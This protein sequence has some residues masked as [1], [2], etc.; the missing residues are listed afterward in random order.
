MLI[1]HDVLLKT[2]KE[3]IQFYEKNSIHV[4]VTGAFILFANLVLILFS[5]L[6]YGLS[7]MQGGYLVAIPGALIF[8]FVTTLL[9]AKFFADRLSR[10]LD[11]VVDRIEQLRENGD[12]MNDGIASHNQIYETQMLENFI[13]RTIAELHHANKVKSIFMMNMSHDFRTPASGILHMSRLIHDRMTDKS[14]QKLQK[15][16]VDSSVQLMTYLEDVL[17]YSILE[18][19]RQ[20]LHENQFDMVALIDEMILFMSTKSHENNIIVRTNYAR[21]VLPYKGDRDVIRRMILNIFSNAIKFTHDGRID[22]SLS[23]VDENNQQWLLIRITDTGI[24]I[25]KSH[26]QLIFEAFYQVEG[27]SAKWRHWHRSE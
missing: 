10:P 26:H 19:D 23:I 20:R 18:N 13:I 21:N 9:L 7:I 3:K 14:L 27:G 1:I 2:G 22:I 15:L 8:A 4:Y 11:A 6:T 25:E 12:A 5:M 24:G 17:D 16:V